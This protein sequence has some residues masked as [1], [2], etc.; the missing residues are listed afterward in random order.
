MLILELYAETYVSVV[1]TFSLHF[2]SRAFQLQGVLIAY[3]SLFWVLVVGE[4]LIH[5]E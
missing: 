1:L 3:Y 5:L 4:S 2:I